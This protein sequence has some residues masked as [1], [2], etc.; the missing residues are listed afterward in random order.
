MT[1]AD[2]DC[3]R[4]RWDEIAATQNIIAIRGGEKTMVTVR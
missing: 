4:R 1:N 3:R 2:V